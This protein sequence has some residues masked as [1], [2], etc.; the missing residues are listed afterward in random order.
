MRKYISLIFLLLPFISKSTVFFVSNSGNNSNNGLTTIT[1]WATWAKV[2]SAGIAGTIGAGDT[3]KFECGGTFITPDAFHGMQWWSP[4]AGGSSPTGTVGHPIVFT[5]YG[6]RSL[7]L[8]N[9][10]FPHPASTDSTSRVALS[11][12]G[13]SYIVVSY[14]QCTDNR[15]SNNKLLAAWTSGFVQ[16]GESGSQQSSHCRIDSC[17][18]DNLGL[19]VVAIGREDSVTNCVMTN[20]GNVFATSAGSFG[21]NG[22]TFTGNRHYFARNYISGAFCFSDTFG[23]NGGTFEQF[24]NTDSCVIEYNTAWDNADICE[25]GGSNGTEAK[26]DTFRF[27]KFI[28]CGNVT[29]VNFTGQV[30]D[31]FNLCYFYNVY[32]ENDSSR[33]SGANFGEGFHDY[34]TWPTLPGA[35]RY[36]WQN[37]GSLTGVTTIYNL[38]NNIFYNTNNMNVYQ[39]TTT[40]VIHLSN[41]YFNKGGSNWGYTPDASESTTALKVFQDTSSVYPYLWNVKMPQNFIPAQNIPGID[42]EGKTSPFRTG[43]FFDLAVPAN[44]IVLPVYIY[45]GSTYRRVTKIQ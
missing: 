45:D 41:I 19:G 39:S 34:P 26:Q 38:Q 28:N 25:F 43:I 10:L 1:A 13:V 18:M 42:W 37:S 40:K 16:F 44:T 36:M 21:C 23:L 22:I 27:N 6:N 31:P 3:V 11:F 12:E 20:F 30:I 5:C 9:T 24:N 4:A 2:R 14:M 8:P 17:Y 33:Y 29:Y 15:Y 35:E 32:I 7:G